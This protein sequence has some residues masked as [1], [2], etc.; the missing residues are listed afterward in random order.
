MLMLWQGVWREPMDGTLELHDKVRDRIE[1]SNSKTLE[2]VVRVL[3]SIGIDALSDEF[4]MASLSDDVVAILHRIAFGFFPPRATREERA[5]RW[6]TYRRGLSLAWLADAEWRRRRRGAPSPALAA[7]LRACKTHAWPLSR[8]AYVRP[9][10]HYGRP[11]GDGLFALLPLYRGQLLMQFTGR[12]HADTRGFDK[13][14]KMRRDYAISAQ[15]G[16]R[17]FRINPLTT[18]DADIDDRNPVGYINEPS[19]PPSSSSV[20]RRTRDV[21]RANVIWINFPV[22]L[23]TLYRPTKKKSGTAYVFRRRPDASIVALRWTRTALASTFASFTDCDT[24]IFKA[25]KGMQ[26]HVKKGYVLFLHEELFRGLERYGNVLSV[27]RTTVTVQHY[28]LPTVAWRLPHRV[29]AA[30]L[31]TCAACRDGVDD[32][33]C[34]SC[35]MVP[36]PL[37]H[38]CRDIAADEELLCL[39]ARAIASRGEPCPTLADHDYRPH[40]SDH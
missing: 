18:D 32:P 37:V 24:G 25:F 14:N 17:V 19:R 9:S 30:K 39:Y 34:S 16:D 29:L 3:K 33:G 12:V 27:D 20:A 23:S 36:F 7:R 8:I 40:W 21:S 11:V 6:S 13:G 38:A 26:A 2:R 10:E 15:H 31:R 4:D 1:F 28:V 22:P 35:V 5:Q